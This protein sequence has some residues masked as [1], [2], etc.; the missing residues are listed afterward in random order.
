MLIGGRG[1]GVKSLGGDSGV[2]DVS[3]SPWDYLR[4]L[5]SL[6]SVGGGM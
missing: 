5:L 4:T 6:A 1:D 3:R 2:W